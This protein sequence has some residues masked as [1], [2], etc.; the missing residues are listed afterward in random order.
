[1]LRGSQFREQFEVHARWTETPGHLLLALREVS[2]AVVHFS[3]GGASDGLYV[4]GE[5]GLP[6]LL[7]C[8]QRPPA[9][10]AER[11]LQREAGRGVE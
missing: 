2:P 11:L 4:V 10:R 5:D 1:V 8:R 9:D 6:Q 7:S 3:G